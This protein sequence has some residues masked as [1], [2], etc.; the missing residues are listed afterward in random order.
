MYYYNYTD[1]VVYMTLEY[2]IVMIR[3]K[4]H[5]EDAKDFI[6]TYKI[7]Y[8]TWIYCTLK[9]NIK[10]CFGNVWYFHL[11]S[12]L[13]S[14]LPNGSDHTFIPASYKQSQ[15]YVKLHYTDAEWWFSMYISCDIKAITFSYASHL[16]AFIN[17]IIKR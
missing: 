7:S 2:C 8:H 11:L 13:F 10:T 9:A 1:V 12:R 3:L 15:D 14:F 5:V 6:Q 4:I 17:T 16:I